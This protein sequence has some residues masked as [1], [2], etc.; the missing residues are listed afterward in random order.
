MPK[1]E[2]VIVSKEYA[3]EM[4]GRIAQ[5]E[6]EGWEILPETMQMKMVSAMGDCYTV[7]AVMA[8]REKSDDEEKI[9]G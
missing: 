1:Y 5:A 3:S 9:A 6:A 4:N 7:F 8:R 2:Y